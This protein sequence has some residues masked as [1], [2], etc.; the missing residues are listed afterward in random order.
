MVQKELDLGTAPQF[1]GGPAS[2]HLMQ[3][4]I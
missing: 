4:W 2:Q 3:V 1:V